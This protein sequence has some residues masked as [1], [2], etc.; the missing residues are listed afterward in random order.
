MRA[1]WSGSISFG[2]VNI[3][4]KLFSGSESR[5]LDLDMLR[6]G[7][8]C[9]IKYLRVCK[10]DNKEVPY[11]EIVK[12]YEYTDGEYIVLTDKDFESASVEKTHLIDILDFVDEREID[13]RYFEKPYYLEPDKSGTKAYALLR[14]ALK[15]SGRV[16]IATFVLRN[17]GSLAVIKPL[18]DLLVLNNIRFQNEIRSPEEL[19]LPGS[20]NLREQEVELALTL[21]DQLTTKFDPAKYKDKYLD[22]LKRVIQEKAQ[23][24][25]PQPAAAPAQPGKVIDMMELLKESLK[26]KKKEAA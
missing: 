7:D 26:Q 21:I 3:P 15:R 8:L 6:K 24:R 16:G 20:E 1:M 22:D 12:G 19:K 18:D 13:T 4:V 11:E 23:G 2:L 14:E 5:T 10:L 17:R 25:E 9:P